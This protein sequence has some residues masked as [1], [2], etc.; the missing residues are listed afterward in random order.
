MVLTFGLN[1]KSSFSAIL[2]FLYFVIGKAAIIH[3]TGTLL[4]VIG[5]I[6]FG[7][8]IFKG[9]KA[10]F[11]YNRL[12]KINDKNIP[13]KSTDWDNFCRTN[14]IQDESIEKVYTSNSYFYDNSF[15]KDSKINTN[16][17]LNTDDEINR[18]LK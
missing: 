13:V 10:T 1:K 3:D 12:I 5:I 18:N 9:L 6:F 2:L 7:I 8:Y 4:R 15:S 14:K 16:N 17:Y 11:T